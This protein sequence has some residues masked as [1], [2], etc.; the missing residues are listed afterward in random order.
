[1]LLDLTTELATYAYALTKTLWRNRA[2]LNSTLL[3]NFNDSI[4]NTSLGQ[5]MA[6]DT[7]MTGASI[8]NPSALLSSLNSITPA[9]NIE[10]NMQATAQTYLGAKVANSRTLTPSQ[11]NTLSILANK[12]PNYD[13]QGVYEARTLLS[14]YGGGFIAYFDNECTDDRNRHR[15]NKPKNNSKDTIK[16]VSFNLY[17]NPNNGNFTLTY[18]LSNESSGR[19]EIYNQIGMKVAEY[20]L[21]SP[22]G[23]MQISN[24]SLSQGLYIYKLYTNNGVKKVGKIVI[25]K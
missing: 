1:M 15:F 21:T 13:G 22:I 14:Y 12:C 3:Q 19:V 6:I 11:L 25:M 9:S 17:P 7:A 20:I 2:L 16:N 10:A 4:N 23:T 24:S 18:D 5:I 8:Y